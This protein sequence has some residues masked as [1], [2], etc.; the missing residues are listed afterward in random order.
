MNNFNK[1]KHKN[2]SNIRMGL[3]VK[4]HSMK[5]KVEQLCEYFFLET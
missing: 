5:E 1:S 3:F 2:N 4:A